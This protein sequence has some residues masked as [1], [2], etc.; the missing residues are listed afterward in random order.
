MFFWT[1]KNKLKNNGFSCRQPPLQKT[2]KNKGFSPMGFSWILYIYWAEI[3]HTTITYQGI[4]SL[5]CVFCMATCNFWHVFMFFVAFSETR[6]RTNHELMA[7]GRL[8][9]FTI[10]V[11]IALYFI[12]LFIYNYHGISTPRFPIHS[13]RAT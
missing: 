5:G 3:L 6:I 8:P 4:C 1:P 2:I 10:L 12:H 7:K 11:I 9:V 13:E